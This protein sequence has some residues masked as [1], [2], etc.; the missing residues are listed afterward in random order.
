MSKECI[1]CSRDWAVTYV[2][3]EGRIRISWSLENQ[4]KK[5]L[6]VESCE[7]ART[8]DRRKE[9]FILLPPYSQQFQTTT[10][11]HNNAPSGALPPSVLNTRHAIFELVQGKGRNNC[12]LWAQESA[13]EEGRRRKTMQKLHDVAQSTTPRSHD[14]QNPEKRP[15]TPGTGVFLFAWV[16]TTLAFAEAFLK[17]KVIRQCHVLCF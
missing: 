4:N 5:G 16:K 17:W 13:K 10:S 15:A 1:V 11:E 8:A 6:S 7:Q 2:M 14:S 9:C 3:C 12:V